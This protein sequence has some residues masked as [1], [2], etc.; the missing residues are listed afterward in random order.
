MQHL[1][2]RQFKNLT[3]FHHCFVSP[4][5]SLSRE[6]PNCFSVLVL[7]IY[8]PALPQPLASVPFLSL[9]SFRWKVDCCFCGLPVYCHFSGKR[10]KHFSIHRVR[11][12]FCGEGSKKFQHSSFTRKLII[13]Y[14][15]FFCSVP[16]HL[17]AENSRST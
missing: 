15:F 9:P 2:T 10:E 3:F 8:P 6:C 13:L 12:F 14:D 16:V 11:F 5:P 17:A 4:P 1:H 7:I